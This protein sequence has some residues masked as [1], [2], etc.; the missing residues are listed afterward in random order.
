MLDL[1][2]LVRTKLVADRRKDQTHL[3][4][5]I[6]VGLIDGSWPAR[7]PP[8]RGPRLQTLLDDPDG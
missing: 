5:M 1:E 3:L 2:A 6:G 4:D 7:F 8:P